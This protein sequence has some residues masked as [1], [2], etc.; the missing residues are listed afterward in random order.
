[1]TTRLAIDVGNSR[2]K[3][4]LFAVPSPGLLPKCMERAVVL[5]NGKMPWSTLQTWKRANPDWRPA[6]IAGSNPQGVARIMAEWPKELDSPPRH[7]TNDESFPMRIAVDEPRQ[8]GIDRL[9][10]AVAVQVLRRN[11]EVAV[12]VDSGTA[13]TVDVV[14]EEG[15]FIGGAI[16]PGLALS[17]LALHHYTALLPLVSVDELGEQTPEALGRNTRAAIQSGLFWGQLGAVKELIERQS[18]SKAQVF[19]TGGGGALL[20]TY[21]PN[22]RLEPHLALQGLVMLGQIMGTNKGQ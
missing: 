22:A 18:G 7:I 8:V 9:L 12:I 17:A 3:L 6:V 11:G 13:T 15:T 14:S 16:L 19:V 5:A 1:M 20:A 4:G 21:L 10:N 2:I